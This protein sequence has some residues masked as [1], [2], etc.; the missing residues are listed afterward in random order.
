MPRGVV[1]ITVYLDEEVNDKSNVLRTGEG[2]QSSEDN[3]PWPLPSLT[4]PIGKSYSGKG[5]IANTVC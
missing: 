4:R 2:R 3:L 5:Q 1:S